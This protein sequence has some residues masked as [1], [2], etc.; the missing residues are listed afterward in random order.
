MYHYTLTRYEEGSLTGCTVS[1]RATKDIRMVR[2]RSSPSHNNCSIM[3]GVSPLLTGSRSPPRHL[4]SSSSRKISGKTS[5]ISVSNEWSPGSCNDSLR[6]CNRGVTFRLMFEASPLGSI[7]L[8]LDLLPTPAWLSH[9]EST[10]L[11]PAASGGGA[12]K[13]DAR[14]YLCR[15][16]L[17]SRPIHLAHSY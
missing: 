15:Q 2:V 5:A 10:G 14:K 3:F 11:F 16:Y 1:L 9:P 13:S 4:T 6:A 7:F 8:R 17:V 12:R